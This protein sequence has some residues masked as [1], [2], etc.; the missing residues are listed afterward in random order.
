[1][2]PFM[3]D[4]TTLP[5]LAAS[6]KRVLTPLQLTTRSFKPPNTLLVTPWLLLQ[7]AL[8]CGAEVKKLWSFECE[9]EE[10]SFTT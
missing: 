1:M 2:R 5:I 8:A 10:K 7:S 9:R 4:R 3:G 6:K